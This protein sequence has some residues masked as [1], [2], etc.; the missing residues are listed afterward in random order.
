MANFEDYKLEHEDQDK[1]VVSHPEMGKFTIARKKL[2]LNTQAKIASLRHIQH[3]DDGGVVKSDGDEIERQIASDA[4]AEDFVPGKNY[5]QADLPG[6]QVASI[7][8][9]PP[10]LPSFSQ[11]ASQSD[12]ATNNPPVTNTPENI[13]PFDATGAALGNAA[14]SNPT[15]SPITAS[16]QDQ[17]A[18]AAPTPG[19][20]IDLFGGDPLTQ[21]QKGNQQQLSGVYQRGQ[22]ES[23]GAAKT[24]ELYDQQQK[25]LQAFQNDWK[26]QHQSLM[27]EGTKLYNDTL[28]GK[29]DPNHYLGSMDTGN[30]ILAA[31]SIAL[32]G[33]GGGVSG[34]GGNVA[35]DVINKAIDRDVEAQKADLNKKQ[36][37]LSVN[38]QRTHSLDTAAEMTAN[39]MRA[40]F[41]AKVQAQASRTNSQVATDNAKI[42]GGQL[43]TQFGE[44][45]MALAQKLA[46]M[47]VGNGQL[48]Q[49]PE[50]YPKEVSER[51][52]KVPGTNGYLPASSADE[53][54]KATDT[55]AHIETIQGQ[56]DAI[57]NSMKDVGRTFP[58]SEADATAKSQAKNLILELNHLHDINRLN[59]TEFKTYV[60]QVPTG[61]DWRQGVAL[62]K[63]NVL[64]QGVQNV[65]QATLN[66]LRGYRKPTTFKPVS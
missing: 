18:T 36:N 34:R 45:S 6:N 32:G 1:F 19:R 21:I 23:E 15:E 29:I 11:P 62:A 2:D 30:R 4:K 24:A 9:T 33:I 8:P 40:M 64:G 58:Y 20:S 35:L 66:K 25:D 3:F 49:N 22:A 37:L 14:G 27:D 65:K 28:S 50:M 60:E 52:V 48:I 57:K 31:I 12:M 51:L 53:A 41:G 38:L 54:N 63:L 55:F 16:P 47:N 39:Q 44:Q 42:L 5:A 7:A 59:D 61:G 43:G 56:I 10:T 46:T 17:A 26:V 13:T